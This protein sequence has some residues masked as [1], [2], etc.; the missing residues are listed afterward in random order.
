MTTICFAAA[1]I[2]YTA[3]FPINHN[4]ER[5]KQSVSVCIG[6]CVCLPRALLLT[7]SDR[8]L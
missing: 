4:L 8:K 1:A 5:C 3:A 2:D 7:V 6:P